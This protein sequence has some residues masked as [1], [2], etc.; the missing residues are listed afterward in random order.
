MIL[1]PRGVCPIHNNCGFMDAKA[2]KL[3]TEF[4]ISTDKDYFF[5]VQNRTIYNDT[6]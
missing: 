5:Y 3:L 1:Y 2:K 4:N 6:I